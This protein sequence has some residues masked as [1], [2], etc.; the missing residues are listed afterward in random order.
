MILLPRDITV[1][2]VMVT[3]QEFS[4]SYEH[5]YLKIINWGIHCTSAHL[6][7]R[8]YFSLN[9]ISLIEGNQDGGV[10]STELN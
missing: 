4:C 3:S 5:T 7:V 6:F 10:G 2:I 1:N 8:M 9:N